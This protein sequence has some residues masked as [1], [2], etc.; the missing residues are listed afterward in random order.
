MG[1]EKLKS[2][3]LIDDDEVSNFIMFRLLNRMNICDN[4][5]FLKNGQEG[6]NFIRKG[7]ST[8][9]LPELIIL[10]I[11]MPVKTGTEFLQALQQ[12]SVDLSAVKIFVL[13]NSIH[14]DEIRLLKSLGVLKIL[15][16]PVTE[17]KLLQVLN[18]NS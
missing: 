10:D 2:V 1:I 18:Y 11:N 5:T 13:S 15:L 9:S 4:I 8:N 14:P 6:L 3:L 7:Y 16:K 17:E 12:S